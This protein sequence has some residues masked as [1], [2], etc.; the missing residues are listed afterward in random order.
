M[1]TSFLV[2]VVLND[3]LEFSM[4]LHGKVI[5]RGLTWRHVWIGLESYRRLALVKL[6]FVNSRILGQAGNS[7][8][9]IATAPFTV[10]TNSTTRDCSCSWVRSFK[11]AKL[12]ISTSIKHVVQSIWPWI[13]LIGCSWIATS[14]GPWPFRIF[15]C[16]SVARS[17][18]TSSKKNFSA[19]VINK[20]CG[21][22]SLEFLI[23]NGI[24]LIDPVLLPL[25]EFLGT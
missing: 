2:N 9:W 19:F 12:F 20:I 6:S 7:S 23:F 17:I 15:I 21:L 8:S 11:K 18:A 24:L 5:I 16:K 22:H 25:N 3:I 4:H 10:I 13:W 1:Q 14:I